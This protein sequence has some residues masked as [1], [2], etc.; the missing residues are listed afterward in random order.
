ME[1]GYSAAEA[2]SKLLAED[3]G[4]AVR[5]VAMVNVHGDVA[6]HTGSKCIFAAG[7]QKEKKLFRTGQ[8][9][10]KRDSLAGHGKSIRKYY[11]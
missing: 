9:D 7:H 8:S 1:Q 11:G 10:G 6:A 2:L 5:Q 3:K 4:Q